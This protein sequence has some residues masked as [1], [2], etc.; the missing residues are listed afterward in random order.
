MLISFYS[1]QHKN[2]GFIVTRV[3]KADKRM[4]C[5]TDSLSTKKSHMD[6]PGTEPR[7]IQWE[8]TVMF[9]MCAV[10]HAVLHVKCLL[11]MSS[12]NQ[13][14]NAVLT[15]AKLLFSTFLH[16]LFQWLTDWIHTYR[17]SIVDSSIYATFC[18]QHAMKNSE[19]NQT[20]F[21]DTNRLKFHTFN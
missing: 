7:S 21:S 3:N 18:Y 15:E 14:W 17:H 10:I 4:Y 19:G 1:F 13:R 16:H 9:E 11:R 8:A 5:P 12:C 6:W 2:S 20:Q